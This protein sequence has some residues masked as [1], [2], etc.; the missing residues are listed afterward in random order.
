MPS[1]N[2]KQLNF[3]LLVKAYKENGEIGVKR[4]WSRLE[5]YKPRLT[6]E[7]M[8]KLSK[9]AEKVLD[10]DLLDL[11]SGIEDDTELGDTREF[12]VGYWA[13]FRGNYKPKDSNNESSKEG[14]FIAQIVRVDHQKRRVHFNQYGFRNK[15]GQTIVIPKR[16]NAINLD[17]LYLDFAVF[18]DVI[19]TGKS[20]QEVAKTRETMEESVR[21][22]VRKLFKEQ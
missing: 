17:Y 19:K 2:K 12:K 15:F 21:E 18:D 8:D 14:E 13:L 6:P 9:T 3:F 1:K 10:A 16:A 7:Y 22:I 4:Q 11:T 20:P 5:G